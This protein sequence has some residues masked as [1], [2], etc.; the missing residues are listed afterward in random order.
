LYHVWTINSGAGEIEDVMSVVA[1][2]GP[3]AATVICGRPW[4]Y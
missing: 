4:L 1:R 2:H 3:V